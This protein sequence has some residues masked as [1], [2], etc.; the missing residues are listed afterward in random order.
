MSLGYND[1]LIVDVGMHV[2]QD[3]EFYLKKGFNVVAVE[4]NPLAVGEASPRLACYIESGQLQILNVG[5]GTEEGYFPFYL[6]HTISEW[7]SFVPERGMRGGAYHEIW[8]SCTKLET[9]LK[10]VGIPYYLKVDIEGKELEAVHTLYSFQER[11]R[12][13]SVEGGSEGI[14]ESLRGLGYDRF[15]FINQATVPQMKCPSPPREGS[16]TDH[17][18]ELGAS[19]LFGE[20][21]EG[22]WKSC[23]EIAKEIDAYWHK[24]DLNPMQD[25]WFDLHAKFPG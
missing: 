13:V 3:T 17:S 22:E 21:T 19:G 7:S 11:P 23:E 14:L 8:V 5:I 10:E 6:N 12:Y 9:I 18:F 20:E 25:G 2:G 24:P 16:Y 15:K 1:R 4:A